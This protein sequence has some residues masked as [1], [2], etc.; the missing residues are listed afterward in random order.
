MGMRGS[1]EVLRV[2]GLLRARPETYL[3]V[4]PK[5]KLKHKRQTERLVEML[6]VRSENQERDHE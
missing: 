3:T 1:N 6:N 4:H 5:E 2:L